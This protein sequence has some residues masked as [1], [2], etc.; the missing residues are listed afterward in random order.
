MTGSRSLR[1]C[2]PRLT[3][4]TLKPLRTFRPLRTGHAVEGV[5]GKWNRGELLSPENRVGFITAASP[6]F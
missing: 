1:S 5:E 3:R 4:N 2:S 6:Y